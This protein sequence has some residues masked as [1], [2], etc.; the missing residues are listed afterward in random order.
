MKKLIPMINEVGRHESGC[1]TRTAEAAITDGQ[2][3]KW[4]TA[5][6]TQVLPCGAGEIPCGIA[7]AAAL[8]NTD[9]GIQLLGAA[10]GTVKL[11][12]TAAAVAAGDVLTTGAAG[13]VVAVTADKTSWLAIGRAVTAVGSA[14]GTIEAVV[15]MPIPHTVHS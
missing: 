7:Q 4:G 1:I 10:T 9:V 13:T 11:I 3:V 2:L 15:C 12:T 8:I 5:P 6:A 14:G